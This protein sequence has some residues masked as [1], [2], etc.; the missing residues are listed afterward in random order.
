MEAK[1]EDSKEMPRK[2][3]E[4]KKM[5]EKTQKE[6]KKTGVERREDG[7]WYANGSDVGYLTPAQARKAAM[8]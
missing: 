4:P 7:R 6:A 3:A 8:G 5:T 1:K 2:T